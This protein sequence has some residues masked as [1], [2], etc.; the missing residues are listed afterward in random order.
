MIQQQVTNMT[1]LAAA[2]GITDVWI[3]EMKVLNSA[4]EVSIN[5]ASSAL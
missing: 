2:H 1:N 3:T 4:T 5:A